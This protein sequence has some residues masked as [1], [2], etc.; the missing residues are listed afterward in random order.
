MIAQTL[1]VGQYITKMVPTI[2]KPDEYEIE[3]MFA[4][5]WF[6]L[7]V[8]IHLKILHYNI[9]STYRKV[10]IRSRP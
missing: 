2:D 8:N 5:V 3:G 4:D 10:V 6:D 7:Q 1:P 9:G